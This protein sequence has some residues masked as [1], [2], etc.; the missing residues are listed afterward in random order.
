MGFKINGEAVPV[1]VF[2]DNTSQVWKLPD[3]MVVP[4][5]P[6]TV[7]WRFFHEMEVM[8][9]MQ[10][11]TLLSS[12]N[13]EISLELPYLPYAR[14]DKGI[15][16]DQCFAFFVFK[17]VL[18]AY[19]PKS[20]RILDAHSSA[21]NWIPNAEVYYPDTEL[22]QAFEDCEADIVCYP[23]QGAAEKYAGNGIYDHLYT[24]A[25]KERDPATGKITKMELASAAHV[26]DRK[27]L[28]VDD[29]CD[30]GATFIE[31]ARL[32]RKA[33]AKE[34]SLFVSHGIFSRG[35]RRLNVGGIDRI[36]TPNGL[37]SEHADFP[38]TT[39]YDVLE[40]MRNND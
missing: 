28:I 29:I 6:V 25:H 36:Y 37:I 30:G 9:Y 34:V 38:L 31:L 27:V 16:N 1:T 8:Q 26:K 17:N 14:Q 24:R 3:H 35:V 23:D 10:L 40:R 12:L 22:K 39:D 11:F 15:F 7:E 20:I 5:E 18:T 32:L 33:G 21:V 13:K 2:P 4:D 19:L